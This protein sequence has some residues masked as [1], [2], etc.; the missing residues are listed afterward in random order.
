MCNTKIDIV[1]NQK[2]NQKQNID[3]CA[4]PAVKKSRVKN[5]NPISKTIKTSSQLAKQVD[6]I[7]DDNKL[8]WIVDEYAVYHKDVKYM[9]YAN[10]GRINGNTSHT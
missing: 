9:K 10:V 8:E 7:S 1:L 3:A 2:P 6:I 5:T 4:K